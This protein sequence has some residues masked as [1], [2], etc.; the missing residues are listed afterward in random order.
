MK[1]MV[2]NELDFPMTLVDIFGRETEI[3][4]GYKC[5][6]CK[7]EFIIHRFGHY[8]RDVCFCPYC[9]APKKEQSEDK[10]T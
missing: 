5:K 8:Y 6:R 4:M 3:A 1:D 10:D 9:G 7:N 2:R